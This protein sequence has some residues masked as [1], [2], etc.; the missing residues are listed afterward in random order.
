MEIRTLEYFLKVA[1]EENITRAAQKLHITQPTMSRQLS[2]LEEELGVILFTRGQYTISL[3]EE[4]KLLQK[5]AQELVQ[6]AHSLEQELKKEEITLAGQISIGCG[7]TK[8]LHFLAKKMMAFQKLHPDVFFDIQTG[9]ADDMIEKLESGS[10]DMAVVVSPVDYTSYQYIPLPEM[11]HHVLLVPK[12]HP[13]AKKNVV[14]PKDLEHENLLVNRRLGVRNSLSHWLG[15]YYDES[16]VVASFGLN[17]NTAMMVEEG[18]GLAFG[19]D[20]DVEYPNIKRLPLD[21]PW[22]SLCTLVYKKKDISIL[23]E[24]FANFIRNAENA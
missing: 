22:T 3:T 14:C 21:P 16:K 24:A 11:D 23:T 13:L 8:N 15:S 1:Q 4:G 6:M 18:M 2:K 20:L 12:G 10:I 5:R 19:F 9:V 17:T 7:E